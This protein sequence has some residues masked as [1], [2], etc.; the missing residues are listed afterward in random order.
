LS[1]TIELLKEKG[2]Q[3]PT[4]TPNPDEKDPSTLKGSGKGNEGL[5]PKGKIAVSGDKESSKNAKPEPHVKENPQASNGIGIGSYDN[6]DYRT[7]EEQE[8][9]VLLEGNTDLENEEPRSRLVVPQE[10]QDEFRNI[11]KITN[12]KK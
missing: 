9:S 3:L 4:K 8:N 6:D 1:K 5:D 10:L 11:W 7:L 2:I 12:S